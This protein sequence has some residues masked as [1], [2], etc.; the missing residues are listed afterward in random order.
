MVGVWEEPV[1]DLPYLVPQEFG[2]R[3]ECRWLELPDPVSGRTLRIDAIGPA[4]LHMSATRHTP[5][6][7][8]ASSSVSELRRRDDLVVCLDVAHRGLG[9]ASCGPDVLAQYRIGAGRYEFGYR[10]AY[11]SGAPS[12]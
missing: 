5:A 8:F 12:G 2:L 3:T 6:E 4:L 7:L 1:D 9:T 10:L 11:V